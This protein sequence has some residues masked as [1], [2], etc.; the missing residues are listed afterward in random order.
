MKKII[1]FIPSLITSFNLI[2]G[3]LATI[4]ALQDEVLI[5]VFFILS[6][7]IFDFLD[8][9]LARLLHATSEFGKQMDS[10]S[11]LI[12][13]GFAPTALLYNLISNSN[14]QYC[15]CRY[16]AFVSILIVVFSALR[17]AKFNI[18]TEQSNEFRG[19]PTPASAIFFVS[20]CL[21]SKE[22]PNAFLT[23]N[24]FTNNIFISI[25]IIVISLLMVSRIKLLALKFKKFSL[26]KYFWQIILI[27]FSIF[28]LI[29]FKILGLGLIIIFYICISIIKNI[30]SKNKRNEVHR[31]N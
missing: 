5:A 22:N 11:D 12:S 9:F 16:F 29:F 30:F 14:P 3:A 1:S 7:T 21:Y 27:L 15:N 25:I 4:L 2:C 26:K 13:F 20:I 23:N 28:F 17:L 24:L 10:L 18:D 19:L 8:G 31:T 6:A